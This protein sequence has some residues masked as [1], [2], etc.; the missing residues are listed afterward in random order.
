MTREIQWFDRET[1][2]AKRYWEEKLLAMMER[3][4][5]AATVNHAV[6]RKE[7]RS[8]KTVEI[9]EKTAQVIQSMTGGSLLLEYAFFLTVYYTALRGVASDG[10][11]YG[12]AGVIGTTPASSHQIFPI[13]MEVN[14]DETV[15]ALL[16]RNL[17]QIKEAYQY[18][19]VDLSSLWKGTGRLAEIIFIHTGLHPVNISEEKSPLIMI[20]RHADQ[21]SVHLDGGS[22][23]P[24][25]FRM[26]AAL[27]ILPKLSSQFAEKAHSQI[28]SFRIA[29]D[30]EKHDL[31][32]MADGRK[33]VPS[34]FSSLIAQFEEQ[35]QKT[36]DLPAIL[37]D[38]GSWTYREFHQLVRHVARDL[39]GRGIG[40][41]DSVAILAERTVETIAAIWAIGM[42]GA[43]YVPIE[44]EYPAERQQY[45]L[46]SS[47]AKLLLVRDGRLPHFDIPVLAL[48]Y[49]QVELTSEPASSPQRLDSTCY[50]IFTSGT[51]GLPKQVK[52]RV[53]D[54]MNLCRWYMD[55][56]GL[57]E[58]SR[59]ML[60]TPMGFDASVKNL[61]APLLCGAAIVLPS[62]SLADAHRMLNHL[63]HHR[64]THV[65]CVPALFYAWAGV[66]EENGYS[67]F[68]SL[69]AVILGGEKLRPEPLAE[70]A[71][72]AKGR[73]R[74]FNVYGPTE[75]TSVS[76]AGEIALEDIAALQEVPIGQPIDHKRIYI[77]DEQRQLCRFGYPGEIY[78]GGMGIAEFDS[79]YANHTVF[80]DSFVE[81][82]WMYKT[83]DQGVWR[84][85]A[86]GER[87]YYL[88]RGDRQRKLNG[89]RID[90]EEIEACIRKHPDIR[91]CVAAQIE[92]EGQ[93]KWV[94]YVQVK[95]GFQL[96][97]SQL[98]EFAS[99]WL[100]APMLP[101]Y[102]VLCEEFPLT[103]N[104]KIDYRAL[105]LPEENDRTT[106][107]SFQVPQSET[108]KLLASIWG[109]VLG[110]K[111]IGIDDHFFELGGDS[112]HLFQAALAIS[113]QMN[114]SI[115]AAD[116]LVYPTIRKLA[117]HLCAPV[118]K[119]QTE[120]GLSAQAR[121]AKRKEL[122]E[123][124]RRK[125]K[126]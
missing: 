62:G 121:A 64:V 74:L 45:M 76:V 23:H 3:A 16:Q 21:Y 73:C 114:V 1:Y 82:G 66:E 43:S 12:V 39:S 77:L 126:R 98:R 13:D 97:R 30:E 51:T 99:G 15:A 60:A 22:A 95:A 28:S 89:H 20:E 110:V 125:E 19:S 52:G 42:I 78:I 24:E 75:C 38:E 18:Q 118:K 115:D 35:V 50:S 49:G 71:V 9:K 90:P 47:G 4:T 41:G 32:R 103:V 44:A 54:V 120:E 27:E 92:R 117:E 111:S 81:E 57:R 86:H 70:W 116:L 58:G 105:P 6:Q 37:S 69:S 65:N 5:P 108:Q 80:P 68:S 79:S 85:D 59:V 10:I 11:A 91:L 124:R 113:N 29:S 119:E 102:A 34:P 40:E 55:T 87:L 25:I 107:H 72:W 94:V 84:K 33:T 93:A 14:P 8:R 96:N 112:L 48:R 106:A 31:L 17:N 123:M 109:K 122:W 53:G 7:S 67:R 36:P 100:P 83:G 104:G 26:K 63:S 2:E 56:C 101:A 61:F 88:G 46:N